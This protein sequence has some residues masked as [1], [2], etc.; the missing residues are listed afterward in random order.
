MVPLNFGDD[1]TGD[2]V[3]DFPD[4][5]GGNGLT[6]A[7]PSDNIDFDSGDL[8]NPGNPLV[9]CNNEDL[10]KFVN[11][12]CDSFVYSANFSLYRGYKV[13]TGDKNQEFTFGGYVG[14]QWQEFTSKACV[15]YYKIYANKNGEKITK[16]I[17]TEKTKDGYFKVDFSSIDSGIYYVST[18]NTFIE[19]V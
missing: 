6:F 8:L 16:T 10:T 14:T 19:L 2:D 15:E 5:L 13:V 1:P 4:N 9:E 17:P 18:Y 11:S 3:D 7:Y 12:N